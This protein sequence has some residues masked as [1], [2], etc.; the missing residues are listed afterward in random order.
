MADAIVYSSTVNAE[1]LC[2]RPKECVYVYVCV[3]VRMMD[4]KGSHLLCF[5]LTSLRAYS[6]LVNT[7]HQSP[8]TEQ[9]SYS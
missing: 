7:R 2:M 3:R 5:Q 6:C 8:L 9:H 1:V 4:S